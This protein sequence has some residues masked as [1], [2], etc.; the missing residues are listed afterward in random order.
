M[1]GGIEL[2]V[3]AVDKQRVSRGET[4]PIAEMPPRLDRIVK[5]IQTATSATLT[6]EKIRIASIT[7]DAQR[8]MGQVTENTLEFSLSNQIKLRLSLPTKDK[9]QDENQIEISIDAR[10]LSSKVSPALAEQLQEIEAEYSNKESLIGLGDE[11]MNYTNEV[12]DNMPQE[13]EFREQL[14]DA[15]EQ[16]MKNHR[17]LWHSHADLDRIA[18]QLMAGETPT[19]DPAW[20]AAREADEAKKAQRE[21]EAKKDAQEQQAN[22]EALRKEFPNSPLLEPWGEDPTQNGEMFPVFVRVKKEAMDTVGQEGLREKPHPF[23]K[24]VI[25][26]IKA[27]AYP[28]TAVGEGEIVLR[29]Y[30][31]KD[32]PVIEGDLDKVDLDGHKEMTL[33]QFLKLGEQQATLIMPEI[34]L[35]ETPAT[36]LR[37]DSVR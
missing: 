22:L 7:V 20:V 24:D 29:T 28:D 33:E 9:E 1:G 31:S 14:V 23:N 21:Q 10:N 15:K 3:A 4:T 25:Q 18:R 30:I 17:G 13:D 16:V 11:L 6:G 8:F 5:Q 27:S 19:E 36:A 26:E 37:V 2:D 34:I 35:P 32:T 12:T